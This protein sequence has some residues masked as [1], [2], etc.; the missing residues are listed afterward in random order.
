M[1]VDAEAD[2]FL[3]I[4]GQLL[5]RAANREMTVRPID[6]GVLKMFTRCRS[7]LES[8]QI[9]LQGGHPEEALDIARGLFTDSL[10]LQK[11]AK[12]Q[13]NRDGYLLKW[14]LTGLDDMEGLVKEAARIGL[15]PIP[16][17]RLAEI[18]ARRKHVTGFAQR[19]GI[20]L[21]NFGDEKQRA[22]DLGR[23]DELIEFKLSHQIVNGGAH[24]Q[25]LKGSVTTHQTHTLALR[26]WDPRAVRPVAGFSGRC[27][28]FAYRAFS[29]ILGERFHWKTAAGVCSPK[30]T[31]YEARW[32]DR[33]T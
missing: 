11:L 30:A 6:S 31:N 10:R 15:D 22:R 16:E 12:E 9:L 32:S 26:N 29:E 4:V 2:R 20:A 23:E 27:A 19:C 18:R 14:E 7:A 8:I 5:S 33:T 13:V 17:Q 1:D 24:S 3:N 21:R 28:L 25:S